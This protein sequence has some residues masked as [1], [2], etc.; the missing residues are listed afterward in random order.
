MDAR[1]REALIDRFR[2]YLERAST[3]RAHQEG[4]EPPDLSTLLAELSA[5]KN[6]VR[7][8][9]RQHRSA[10]DQ[11]AESCEALRRE[12]L[13]L[14]EDLERERQRAGQERAEGEHEVLLELLELRDHLAA[15]HRQALGYRPGVIARLGGARKYLRSMAQGL[16]MNLRHLDEI[17]TRR[18]VQ[19]QEVIHR[20][21]DP[22]TMHAV[23]TIMDS[24]KADGTVVQEVRQGFL[25]NGRL[26]RTA[27]VIVNK[28]EGRS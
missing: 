5:L 14:R 8:D 21:F 1:E 26:L 25:R 4:P 3:T 7:I 18:G 24:G 10:L 23:D 28:R 27:Q 17:L 2:D 16:E 11:L 9:A 13:Q 22:Q 20:P 19:A 15:G 12:N 6:D